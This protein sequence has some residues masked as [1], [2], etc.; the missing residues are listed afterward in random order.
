LAL[1]LFEGH[2]GLFE[3]CCGLVV[4]FEGRCG[5]VVVAHASELQRGVD[6]VW[7]QRALGPW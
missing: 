3:S 4:L 7:A 2:C 6:V 1:V 5:L